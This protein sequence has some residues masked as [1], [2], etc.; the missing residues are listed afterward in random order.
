MIMSLNLDS[1]TSRPIYLRY[2]YVFED[3]C[4]I[5]TDTFSRVIGPTSI[6]GPRTCAIYKCILWYHLWYQFACASY[7]SLSN[8]QGLLDTWIYTALW[9]YCASYM[10]IILVPSCILIRLLWYKLFSLSCK[11]FKNARIQ[12]LYDWAPQSLSVSASR[13][14]FYHS[15]SW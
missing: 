10:W 4:R 12:I 7:R 2:S 6:Y 14:Y 13:I 15:T 11:G 9:G 8:I 1:Q 3:I 5:F